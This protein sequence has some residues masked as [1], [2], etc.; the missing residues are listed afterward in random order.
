MYIYIGENTN[1]WQHCRKAQRKLQLFGFLE[2]R[3]FKALSGDF[4]AHTK[5]AEFV[6]SY[7]RLWIGGNILREN[8]FLHKIKCLLSY[9]L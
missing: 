6:R 7:K 2:F 4:F 1:I 3:E 8:T 9:K 5:W